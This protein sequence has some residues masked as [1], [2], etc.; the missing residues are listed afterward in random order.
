MGEDQLRVHQ[1]DGL[2][3]HRTV[4]HGLGREAFIQQLIDHG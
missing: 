2:L 1:P 4:R 3:H